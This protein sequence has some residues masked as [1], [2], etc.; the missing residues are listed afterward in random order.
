MWC[1]GSFL[2]NIIN[3]THTSSEWCGEVGGSPRHS[4]HGQ[5]QG[6]QAFVTDRLHPIRPAASVHRAG[7]PLPL[8]GGKPLDKRQEKHNK[9][10]QNFSFIFSPSN[11]SYVSQQHIIHPVRKALDYYTEME[12]ALERESQNW[13]QSENAAKAKET[14]ADGH[15]DDAPSGSKPDQWLKE[16]Q[17]WDWI[18][19]KLSSFSTRLSN[20]PAKHKHSPVC[21][22]FV[23]L[24]FGEK[25]FDCGVKP[26]I[27]RW[28]TTILFFFF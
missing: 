19:V 27:S 18:T 7:K 17:T 12:K 23:A 11:S 15:A 26:L 5:R 16:L 2:S 24:V 10:R 22:F 6:D 14:T 21:H 1:M 25:Y 13:A 3:P 28:D 20:N 4:F 8:L 9:R